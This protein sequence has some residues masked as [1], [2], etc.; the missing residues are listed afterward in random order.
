MLVSGCKLKHFVIRIQWKPFQC[1]PTKN[2]IKLVLC[3]S[4]DIR[5]T[6]T[7]NLSGNIVS[8]QV[9]GRCF[10]FFALCDQLVVQQ[11]HLLQ[12]EESCYEK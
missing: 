9:S 11:N 10:V 1:I 2:F 7:F 4:G 12:V 6:K 8:L 5:D 3:K